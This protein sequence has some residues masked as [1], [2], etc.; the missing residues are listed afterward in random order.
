M[1]LSPSQI[2]QLTDSGGL[3]TALLRLDA[4]DFEPRSQSKR[5][6]VPPQEDSELYT[7]LPTAQRIGELRVNLEVLKGDLWVVT[8]ALKTLAEKQ[9]S[10][11]LKT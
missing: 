6:L 2:R 8:R 1:I 11:F 4:P 9:A 7:F 5:V 3:T 10:E